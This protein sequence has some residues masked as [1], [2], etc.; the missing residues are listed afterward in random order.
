M[1]GAQEKGGYAHPLQGDLVYGSQTGMTLRDYFAG[2][3]L[4]SFGSDEL[5]CEPK[6][7]ADWAYRIADAMLE[8][9]K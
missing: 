3:A 2:Q 5:G 7:N 4:S 1:S 8:A 6:Q 9:R